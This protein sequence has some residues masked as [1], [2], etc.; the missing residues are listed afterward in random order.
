MKRTFMKLMVNVAAFAILPTAYSAPQWYFTYGAGVARPYIDH[1]A[2]VNNNSGAMP[3]Y[4]NDTYT[5]HNTNGAALLFEL[6]KRWEISESVLKAFM[7]GF[8]YQHI[9]PTNIGKNIYQYSSPEFLNYHYDLD[10]EANI[11]LL[12]SKMELF[13]WKKITPFIN[14]G[15]GVLQLSASDYAEYAVSNVTPRTSPNFQNNTSYRFTYQLGFGLSWQ[16]SNA[17]QASIS[18]VYQPLANF[19]TKNGV[20]TWSNRKLSYGDVNA[21]AIFFTVTRCWQEN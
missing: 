2:V 7:L 1:S 18:Y 15:V 17:L 3:P 10:L 20:Q 16:L 14:V 11:L 19:A 9:L 8:Q 4:N 12:N 13:S 21:N 6:G 5:S